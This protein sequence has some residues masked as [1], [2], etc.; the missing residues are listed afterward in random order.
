MR[1]AEQSV[2]R[3]LAQAQESVTAALDTDTATPDTG[4]A[5][6]DTGT[7]APAEAPAP[8][9]E[10]AAQSLN[11]GAAHVESSPPVAP[12]LEGTPEAQREAAPQVEKSGA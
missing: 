3:D 5:A 1:A 6:P 9:A 7:A 11:G 10:A 2:E 12:T 8:E 4:T